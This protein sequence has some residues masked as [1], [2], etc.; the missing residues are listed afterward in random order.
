[1]RV[2]AIGEC[3]IELS[4]RGEGQLY[5]LGFG[6]DTLNTAVYLSR[7][8][9]SVD[10]ATALGDDAFSD[11]MIELW[12]AEG[13]GT[14]LV[15]RLKGRL[16]GL[17][18]IE[19]G[20]NGE[21]QF[22]YWR[23]N[24]PARELFAL[25]E[26][27]NLVAALARYD[28]IYLSGI[29]LSLYGEAGREVLLDALVNAR[30][31]GAKVAFDGNY[32]PRGWASA[33]EARHAM[34]EIL[35]QVDIALAGLDDER[36]LF[37]VDDAAT[38]IRRLAATGV[39]E[40]VVKLGSSGAVV[41][42]HESMV[43]VAAVPVPSPLD[44]TAAGDSFNAGYLAGRSRGLDPVEAAALGNRLAATVISHP[45]AIVPKEAMPEL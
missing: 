6:G 14:G 37:G 45:G 1:M 13:V 21:R 5:G 33:G 22:H 18:L 41:A 7:L 23:Q 36:A 12:Q 10:Y 31:H 29:T 30:R 11:R 17:Y 40:V 3:M 8:G 34:T 42:T 43:E 39:D 35:D 4:P 27:D 19:T 32:R 9:I 25:P 20:A 44:T 26:T 38:V 28:L 16:P 2:A 15:A 24:A